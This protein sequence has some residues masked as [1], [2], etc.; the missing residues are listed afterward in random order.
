M[1]KA[2][3][4]GTAFETLIVDW[5][6]SNGFPEARRNPLAGNKD[7]GDI[8]GLVLP[9][10]LKNVNK[11]ALAQWLKEAEVEAAN[12]GA[13]FCPVVHKRARVGD[14]ARQYVTME[15]WQFAE[16]LKAYERR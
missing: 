16:L 3:Q 9:L 14:A 4:K 10:E 6:R 12:A 15:L 1:S 7:V 2:R 13:L 11:M 5:L 8:G